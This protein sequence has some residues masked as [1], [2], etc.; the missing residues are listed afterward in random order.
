MSRWLLVVRGRR[1]ALAPGDVVLGRG[2]E[3]DVEVHDALASRRHA[4]LHVGPEGV[5]AEDLGSRNGTLL[6]GYPLVGT[7]WLEHGSTLG[8]GD[9]VLTLLEEERIDRASP[10]PPRNS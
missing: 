8:I 1:V 7:P 3:C 10:A 4:I 5:T 9:E 6:D 2:N